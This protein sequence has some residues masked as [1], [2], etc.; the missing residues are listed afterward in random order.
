[1]SKKKEQ[2]K[3]NA[4]PRVKPGTGGAAYEERKKR[5]I[6]LYIA[7]G[8]NATKAAIDVGFSA[9]S[10]GAQASRL[11][12]D[13]NVFAELKKRQTELAQTYKL[14]SESVL[15]QLA[16]IVY[17]DP[18]KCFGPDGCLLPVSEWPDEVA[19]MVSSVEVDALYEGHGED[20]RQIGVT[21]KVKFWDKNSA[22]EKAMKHLGQFEKDNKQKHPVTE[23]SMEQLEAFIARK[24]KEIAEAQHLH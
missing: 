19:A 24:Q 1:M 14:D 18:R 15:E 7:N 11:L 10:A 16:K 17:A 2:P 22:I 3:D 21:Q 23:M 20:R 6:E 9:K 4:A 8:G 5:F 12:K 13:I